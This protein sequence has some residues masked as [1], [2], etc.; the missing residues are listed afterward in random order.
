MMGSAEQGQVGEVGGA[1]VQPVPEMVGF[2]PGRGPVA[3]G[4]RT[5]AVADDQGSPLGSGDDAA[6]PADLQRLG[7]GAAQGRGSRV[8]AVRSW[9]ARLV[10]GVGGVW[11]AVGGGGG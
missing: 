4:D 1:A 10:V 2:A 6:G 5:A 9:P 11:L 8:A 3:A 7:G